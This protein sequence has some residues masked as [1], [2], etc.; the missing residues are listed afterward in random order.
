MWCCLK[1]IAFYYNRYF[2]DLINPIWKNWILS[3]FFIPISKVRQRW[4]WDSQT[5]AGTRKKSTSRISKAYSHIAETLQ[6]I[7]LELAKAWQ[8]LGFDL[9]PAEIERFWVSITSHVRLTIDKQRSRTKQLHMLIN[10]QCDSAPNT[11]RPNFAIN[12]LEYKN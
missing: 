7:S 1:Q 9:R 6:E 4:S 12:I 8:G 10:C 3:L 5:P 2:C 11:N